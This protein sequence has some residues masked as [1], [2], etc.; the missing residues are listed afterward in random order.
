LGD[1][2]GELTDELKPGDFIKTFVSGG[3]KCYAYITKDGETVTKMRGITLHS[4]AVKVINF[5]TLTEM[6]RGEGPERV[7][8][9]DPHKI[10]RDLKNKQI[11]SK[12]QNKDYRVVYT[13]RIRVGDFDT[14]PYGYR[15]AM[16]PAPALSHLEELER[17]LQKLDDA[18]NK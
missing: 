1:N 2:L 18:N 6:V 4:E 10:V 9:H 8:V 11:L 17:L 12:P 13:K 7:T 5:D 14:I 3:P 16:Q 15:P